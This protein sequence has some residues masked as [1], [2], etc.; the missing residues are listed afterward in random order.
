MS[1]V[2]LN[3]SMDCSAYNCFHKISKCKKSIIIEVLDGKNFPGKFHNSHFYFLE[4]QNEFLYLSQNL[5]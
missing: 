4:A 1:M 2:K 5:E 3:N